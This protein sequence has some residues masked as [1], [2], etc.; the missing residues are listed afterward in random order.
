MAGMQVEV[1]HKIA[2][3]IGIAKDAGSRFDRK[4]K[5]KTALVIF[6]YG[7][8]AN[9]HHALPDGMAVA[10]SREMANGVEH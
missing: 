10:I 8:H 7:V 4:L 1:V 2:I 3:G 9:F 6:A 5:N